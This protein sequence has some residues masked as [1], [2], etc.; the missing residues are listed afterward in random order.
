[1][2]DFKLNYYFNLY[3][4]TRSRNRKYFKYIFELNHGPYDKL[5]ELMSMIEHYQIKK[6]GQ[7]LYEYDLTSQQRQIIRKLNASIMGEE[8]YVLK[9]GGKKWNRKN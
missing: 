7:M 2:E 1:M 9:S 6:Y 8:L 4:D 3:K 5:D